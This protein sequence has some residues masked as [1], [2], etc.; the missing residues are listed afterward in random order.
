[1]SRSLEKRLQEKIGIL[2]NALE[3]SKRENRK[4]TEIDGIEFS[5]TRVEQMIVEAKQLSSGKP[6]NEC[7]IYFIPLKLLRE[8][9]SWQELQKAI[10]RELD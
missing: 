4:T 3:D 5:V 9:D 8:N 1:M 7:N 6:R 10:L 2:Q